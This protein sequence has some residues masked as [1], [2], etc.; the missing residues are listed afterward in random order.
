MPLNPGNQTVT[1]NPPGRFV[2]DRLHTVPASSGLSPFIQGGSM[3]QIA[4]VKDAVDNTAYAEATNK[5][6]TPYNAN[7]SSVCA[8]WYIAHSGA[9]YRILGCHF[10][11]DA[12]GRVFQ[13]EFICKEEDSGSA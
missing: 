1:F 12:Y 13:C 10:E 5:I 3:I 4:G 11:P 8:E 6:Y 2:V 7:T 9:N